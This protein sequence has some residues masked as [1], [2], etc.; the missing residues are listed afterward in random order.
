M[1]CGGVALAIVLVF[2]AIVFSV[3]ALIVAILVLVIVKFQQLSVRF[4]YS[5]QKYHTPAII[6]NYGISCS[7]DS[8]HYVSE[9]IFVK[10]A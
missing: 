6:A 2:A 1:V 7:N 5:W 10:F 4:A 8:Y 9:D 3:A